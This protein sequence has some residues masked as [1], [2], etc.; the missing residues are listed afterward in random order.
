VHY[1]LP[2]SYLLGGICSIFTKQS[3]QVM[4]RRSL[5]EY[6][7]K[8]PVLARIEWLLHRRMNALIGNSNSV[9]AQ[10]AVEGAPPDRLGVIFNGFEG[11]NNGSDQSV[12]EIQQSLNIEPSVLVLVMVA[13]LIAYKGHEDALRAVALAQSYFSGDWVMLCVGRD[14]GIG[15]SLKIFAQ[16]IGVGEKIRWLGQRNDIHAILKAS[17]I[18]ILCSHEEGF[19]NVVLE[20]MAAGLPMIVTDVGGNPEAVIDG[21]TGLVVPSRSPENLGAAIVQLAQ[22]PEL[23]KEMGLSGQERVR[24]VF[25]LSKCVEDYR[26]LYEGLLRRPDLAVEKILQSE[27]YGDSERG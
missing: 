23:R 6:Q 11:L 16:S 17:D 4:S 25:S 13:N 1:F 9:V 26:K 22:S 20:G 8:Y 24:K 27:A 12:S 10:L 21:V 2:A 5:N 3:L 15:T 7:K 14:D 19:S 18:G